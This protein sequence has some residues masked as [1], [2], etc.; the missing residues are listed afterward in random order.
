MMVFTRHAFERR[1]QFDHEMPPS[2]WDYL[3]ATEHFPHVLAI[4][5]CPKGHGM[6]I[7][8][9]IHAIDHSGAISPSVVC[10]HEGCGFHD[11]VR[12][13]GWNPEDRARA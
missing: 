9:R 8:S 1:G 3:D 4:L 7:V 13:D 11:H 12:L 6:M 10:R 5:N 2:T